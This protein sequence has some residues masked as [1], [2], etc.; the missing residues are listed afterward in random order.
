MY[1]I[2]YPISAIFLAHEK[3]P[4]NMHFFSKIPIVCPHP[5][6]IEFTGEKSHIFRCCALFRVDMIPESHT[7]Y[8][9]DHLEV[10]TLEDQ[11]GI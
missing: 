4:S 8:W 11:G 6:V 10:Y 5:V 9:S 2:I 7:Y 1:R 3:Y